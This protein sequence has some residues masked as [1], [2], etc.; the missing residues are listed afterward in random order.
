LELILYIII[1]IACGNSWRRIARLAVTLTISI[2]CVPDVCSD[3]SA[4]ERKHNTDYCS[5]FNTVLTT[6]QCNL[7]NLYYKTVILMVLSVKQVIP[8]FFSFV[9]VQL[10]CHVYLGLNFSLRWKMLWYC[11]SVECWSDSNRRY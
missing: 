4:S 5:P 3:T 11:R 7:R 9:H 2:S 8:S 10:I 1:Y 6:S